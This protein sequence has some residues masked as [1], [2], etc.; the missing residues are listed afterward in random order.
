MT[1]PQKRIIVAG[2]PK[3]GNTW[4]TRL[5]ADLIDCPARGFLTPVNH[6][7]NACE[8][9]DRESE[10]ACYKS[11]HQWHEL[12]DDNLIDDQT[13]VIY[14][15][16]DPRDV[17]VSAANFFRLVPGPRLGRVLNPIPKAAA[18]YGA[19]GRK[20]L[21]EARRIRRTVSAVLNGNAAV[22]H[23]CRVSWKTHVRPFRDNNCLIVRYEDLLANAAGECE[24]ILQHLRINKSDKDVQAAVSRQSFQ[25]RKTQFETE[26]NRRK[27]KFMRTGRRNQWR[28][29]LT[30]EQQAEFALHLGFELSQFGYEMQ[31]QIAAVAEV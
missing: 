27:A 10:Y 4:A 7:D 2:Y 24:R 5:I 18:V 17:A 11:H 28:E 22:H 19:V 14:I 16:R 23:W 31:P 8:G 6:V 25:T 13:S 12:V 15:V 9:D 20:L 21:P 26:G 30:A 1:D 29:K 3:S